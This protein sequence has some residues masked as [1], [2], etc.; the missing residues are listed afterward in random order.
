MTGKKHNAN[1]KKHGGKSKRG[2]NG[3]RSNYRLQV[4]VPALRVRL[5]Y[6]YQGALVESAAALGVAYSFR[7]NDVFDPDFSGGGLQPLGLD[8]YAQFYGR[9]HVWGF[10]YEVTF[11]TRTQAP[12]YVGCHFAAQSTLPAVAIAWFV[13]NGT[14]KTKALGGTTGS[15]NVVVI[16]G[17]ANIPD[18]LGVKM[19]EY[20]DQDFS[21]AVAASPARPAY[22]HVWTVGRTTVATTDIS[23]RLWYDTEFSQPVALGMS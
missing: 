21:A 6:S 17:R 18:V 5:P 7:I 20:S 15:N 8:Q 4:Q 9:Y 12:I 11:S 10:R 13:T 23:V 22:L 14:V 19:K 1:H 3:S 16:R 2:G